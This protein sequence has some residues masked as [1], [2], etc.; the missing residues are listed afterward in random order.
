MAKQRLFPEPP[1]PDDNTHTAKERFSALAGKVFSVPRTEIERRE[2][3]W[4]RSHKKR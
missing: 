3:E 1:K 2:R 4:K